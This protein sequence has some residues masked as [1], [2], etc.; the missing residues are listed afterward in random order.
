MDVCRDL[1]VETH[2]LLSEENLGFGYRVVEEFVRYV[3]FARE[4]GA[5]NDSELLDDQMVQKILPKMQGGHRQ[6]DMLDELESR[7][8]THDLPQS[9]QKIRDLKTELKNL[10]S[11]QATR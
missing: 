4:H 2:S 6:R 11:F 3:S 7:F 8:E 5:Q 1:L 9:A 10:G